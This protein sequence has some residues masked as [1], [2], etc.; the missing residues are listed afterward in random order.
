ML[1][2]SVDNVHGACQASPVLVIHGT[3]KFLLRVARPDQDVTSTTTLGP[4]Y[5]TVLFWKPQVALFVNERTL[6]PVMV[7]LAPASG[8]VDRF[9]GALA[10]MLRAQEVEVEFIDHEL[11]E[12]RHVSLRSTSNR[13]VVGVM[14]E[15]AFLAGDYREDVPELLALSSR[16]A[17]TPCGPL[18]K[19]KG[20]PDLELLAFIEETSRQD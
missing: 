3:R 15:F 6:F 13:S 18:R 12:M 9:R 4:W 2:R 14:N 1:T 17:R 5:A 11:A 8:V 7:P 20:F 19:S 10:A 16:L